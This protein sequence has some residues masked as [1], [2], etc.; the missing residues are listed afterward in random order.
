MRSRPSD[1][2]T[3]HRASMRRVVLAHRARNPRVFGSVARGE[4]TGASDL[5]LLVEA[6]ETTSLFD[7]AAIELELEALL[8]CPVHVMTDGAL[9][10][11]L[12]ERV[13]ADA[14]PV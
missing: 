2:F 14:E 7:L 6:Q 5:D 9:R 1:V 3:A 8:G 4:D 13:L 11:A 12:R 10:G